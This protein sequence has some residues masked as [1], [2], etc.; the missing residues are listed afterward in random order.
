[1]LAGESVDDLRNDA[2]DAGVAVLPEGVASAIAHLQT[3]SPAPSPRAV[4]ADLLALEK[5]SKRSQ[6]RYDYRQ[7]LGTWRLGFI[8]GTAKTRQRAGTVLGAGRFLPRFVQVQLRYEAANTLDCGGVC[9]GGVRE[10]DVCDEGTATPTCPPGPIRP[11]GS[12]YNLVSLASLT[13]QLQ[14]PTQYWPKTNSLAFDFTQLQVAIG[15]FQLYQQSIRGGAERATQFFAEGLKTQAFFT[16]FLVTPTCLA[17]RGRGGGL[18]LW[19]RQ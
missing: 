4:V 12:A 6:Q 1:M 7:L 19:T 16:Y 18:A 11:Q 17:A 9:E 5:T 3:Q 10:G 14:G 2:G 15:G 13:L 8:T